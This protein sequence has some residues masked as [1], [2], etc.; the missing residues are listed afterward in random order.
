MTRPR[1]A[2]AGTQQ[3]WEPKFVPRYVRKHPDLAKR[4]RLAR[5]FG[6]D[7]VNAHQSLFWCEA[8]GPAF[9]TAVI[10]LIVA[11]SVVLLTVAVEAYRN[12]M[13]CIGA[14]VHAGCSH[15]TARGV[16]VLLLS[17]VPPI[18]AFLTLPRMI[19]NFVIVTNVELMKCR[20]HILQVMTD[21]RNRKTRKMCDTLV[22]LG[23]LIDRIRALSEVA[24]A[25]GAGGRNSSEFARKSNEFVRKSLDF[26][27]R[28]SAEMERP[29]GGSFE[30]EVKSCRVSLDGVGE[31]VR[32]SLDLARTVTGVSVRRGRLSQEGLTMDNLDKVVDLMDPSTLANLKELFN[33][34][35]VGQTGALDRASLGK[36]LEATGTVVDDEGVGFLF[37][38][39]DLRRDGKVTFVEFAA[40]FYQVS[41]AHLRSHELWVQGFRF[42][43]AVRGGSRRDG[44][45][46]E[47]ARKL[48]PMELADKVWD[49]LDAKKVG[50]VT[51]EGVE[52][53]LHRVRPTYDCTDILRL[54]RRIDYENTG[55]VDR[56]RFQQYVVNVFK[57]QLEI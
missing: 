15:V 5:Y 27:S 49:L 26:V 9:L 34:V 18:T 33:E 45:T 25:K 23:T 24:K 22:S 39:M 53:T 41:F 51:L 28:R 13:L 3:R 48:D 32:K 35:D 6:G 2:A 43:V 57:N 20:T 40:V 55:R 30:K 50:F 14:T 56:V 17:L 1:Q 7:V 54:I 21:T 12:R 8:R 46:Q 10:R 36:L 37:D 4:S 52:S 44:R 42:L 11:S 19:Q 47:G 38:L 16:I 29:A 31:T